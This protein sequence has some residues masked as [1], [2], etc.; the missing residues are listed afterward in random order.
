MDLQKR[1]IL[2]RNV[3]IDRT[4][5]EYLTNDS[6]SPGKPL[7][8]RTLVAGHWRHYWVGKGRRYRE[9]KWIEPFWRGPVDAPIS[10]AI[11]RI[12]T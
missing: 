8:V 2:G 9:R 4:V 10:T 1:V 7:M 5:T 3:K 12:A 11:Q 6:S